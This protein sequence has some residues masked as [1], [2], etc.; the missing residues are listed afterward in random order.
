MC[1]SEAQ[2][3][4]ESCTAACGEPD[5]TPSPEVEP[6][7]EPVS[8]EAACETDA[9]SALETCMASGELETTCQEEAYQPVLDK[10]L[11]ACPTPP[12]EGTSCEDACL[13]H[14][15]EIF[16]ACLAEGGT[17]EACAAQAGQD[18]DACQA[19]CSGV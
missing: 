17:D 19:E 8:C 6:T 14:S 10:C 12:P 11:A 13:E 1:K 7:P 9:Q 3:Q 5:A 18:M 4:Q 2:A 16:D 15:I